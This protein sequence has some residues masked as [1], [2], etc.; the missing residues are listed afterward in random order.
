MQIE[1]IRNFDFVI[2]EGNRYKINTHKANNSFVLNVVFQ[3]L[4]NNGYELYRLFQG[5]YV[6]AVK[7]MPSAN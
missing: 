1:D 4:K 3:V 6:Y 2:D 5:G 7:T